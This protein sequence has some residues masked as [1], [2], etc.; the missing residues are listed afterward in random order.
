MEAVTRNPRSSLGVYI[1]IP[2]KSFFYLFII[3]VGLVGTMFHVRDYHYPKGTTIFRMVADFQG[4]E[5][6]DDVRC[7]D[8]RNGPLETSWNTWIYSWLTLE[9]VDANSWKTNS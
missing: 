7:V 5:S 4:I 6:K 8:I 1:Y 2:W 3:Y 9:E